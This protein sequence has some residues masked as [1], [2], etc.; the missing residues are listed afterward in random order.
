MRVRATA[1]GYY[2]LRRRYEGDVFDLEK[3]SHFSEKWMRKVKAKPV[4]EDEEE[5]PVVKKSRRVSQPSVRDLDAM[6]DR[7]I[8]E[9]EDVI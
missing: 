9:S 8:S 7:K 4:E 5:A 1:T 3:D 6:T 2:Q